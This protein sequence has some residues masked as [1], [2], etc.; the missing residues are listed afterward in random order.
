MSSYKN[1]CLKVQAF[2][3]SHRK[4]DIDADSPEGRCFQLCNQ[5]NKYNIILRCVRV[6]IV[7]AEAMSSEYC[8]CVSVDLPQLSGMH[9][10][11]LLQPVKLPPVLCLDLPYFPH[12][13]INDTILREKNIECKL[14]V[15]IFSTTFGSL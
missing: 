1:I 3:R 15:Q 2:L 8:D 11:S 7:A 10:I 12:D 14:C 4:K 5:T 6:N 9:I 13:L